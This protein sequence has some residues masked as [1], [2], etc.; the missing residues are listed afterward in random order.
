MLLKKWYHTLIWRSHRV[1]DAAW[2]TRDSHYFVIDGALYVMHTN[3]SHHPTDW[4]WN[5]VTYL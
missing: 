4:I 2:Q 5:L 1:F 3:G